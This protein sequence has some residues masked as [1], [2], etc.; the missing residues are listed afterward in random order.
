MIECLQTDVFQTVVKNWQFSWIILNNYHVNNN[1]LVLSLI[2]LRK[3]NQMW[4]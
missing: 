2:Y 1:E 3:V 4:S